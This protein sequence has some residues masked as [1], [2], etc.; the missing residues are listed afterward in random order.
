[1]SNYRPVSL[2]PQFSKILEKLF[3]KKLDS[4]IEKYGLLN[5][6]QNGF[7]SNRSTSLA[8]MEFV[9]SIATVVD[10]KPFGVG[11]FID[12]RKAFDPIDHPLLQ[13]K[14]ERYGIRGIAQLWLSSYLYNRFPYC[15]IDDFKSHLKHVTCGVPR[16]SILGPKLFIL[17][18]ND[19]A[20]ALKQL[21]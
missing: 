15:S 1:M 19:L 8:V 12:L 7:R 6:H 4:F 13:Q 17:Y 21:G 11:V 20:F 18:I 16:G 9:E 10:N 14:C 3:V 5:D 2:L